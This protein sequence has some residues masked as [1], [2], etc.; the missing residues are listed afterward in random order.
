MT[1]FFYPIDAKNL[2]ITKNSFQE[3]LGEIENGAVEQMRE[4]I[5]Y[6][7]GFGYDILKEKIHN[8]NK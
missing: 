7:L 3:A 2:E 6:A 5:D 8:Q 4:K 1:S